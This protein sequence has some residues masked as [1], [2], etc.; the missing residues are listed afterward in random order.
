MDLASER[1]NR[2]LEHY[3]GH[4]GCPGIRCDVLA[5]ELRQRAAELEAKQIDEMTD[6]ERDELADHRIEAK[7][8]EVAERSGIRRRY[9]RARLT[10]FAEY[11]AWHESLDALEDDDDAWYRA[12]KAGGIWSWDGPSAGPGWLI[13]GPTGVGKTH[14][15]AAILIGVTGV[16]LHRPRFVATA[17]LLDAVKRAWDGHYEAQHLLNAVDNADLIVLDDL[18]A[19]NATE[20]SI[21]ELTRYFD[22]W[23][24]NE[25]SLIV[26]SNLD[27]RQL[28]KRYG[29]RLVSRLGELTRPY[30]MSG[31]DRRL[32][33][34]VGS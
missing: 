13:T 9:Q 8:R 28:A 27:I 29:P 26:T 18:G 17:D 34:V 3:Q 31:T 20:W 14:L 25:T 12:W 22:N 5:K 4:A 33:S 16:D 24:G 15:A 2:W 19:E 1:Q 21:G 6:E 7:R 30:P 10:D 32:L 23:C 11:R